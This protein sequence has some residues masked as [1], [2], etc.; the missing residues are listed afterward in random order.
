M[1]AIDQF[2]DLGLT[3]QVTCNGYDASLDVP[4]LH[5]GLPKD[6]DGDN[7]P[8][9]LTSV[10]NPTRVIS[11]HLGGN[12]IKVGTILEFEYGDE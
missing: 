7:H 1:N 11:L 5:T 2:Q 9:V 10:C 4:Y 12:H 6:Y 8:H 3:V